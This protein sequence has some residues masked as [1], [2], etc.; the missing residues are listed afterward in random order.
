MDRL[1]F[2]QLFLKALPNST[3]AGRF[4]LYKI[5]KISERSG[6]GQSFLL[7]KPYDRA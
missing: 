4:S 5:A 7:D 1:P 2:F 6:I 3:A